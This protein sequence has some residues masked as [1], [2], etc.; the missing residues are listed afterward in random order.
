MALRPDRLQAQAMHR[1]VLGANVARNWVVERYRADQEV[2]RQAAFVLG[3]HR[4]VHGPLPAEREVYK[5]ANVAALFGWGSGRV[6]SKAEREK[7][8]GRAFAIE[9]DLLAYGE[10]ACTAAMMCSIMRIFAG[11]ARWKVK[12]GLP[13]SFEDLRWLWNR[14]KPLVLPWWSECSKEAL[15]SGIEMGALAIKNHRESLRGERLGD[16]VGMPR[17]TSIHDGRGYA[18]TTGAFGLRDARH[19]RIPKVPGLVKLAEDYEDLLGRIEAGSARL[20]RL[21]VRE[22]PDGTY[23][24]ALGLAVK[25]ESLP[26][27]SYVPRGIDLGCRTALMPSRGKPLDLARSPRRTQRA[28]MF[29]NASGV[30]K[31]LSVTP[32][33]T[34]VARLLGLCGNGE[35]LAAPALTKAR[36]WCKDFDPEHPYRALKMLL[37]NE[38]A[39][40]EIAV[41]DHQVREQ[42]TR[43][44]VASRGRRQ[45]RLSGQNIERDE[46]QRLGHS[47][48][49]KARL[50]A[51]RAKERTRR[52]KQREADK[53]RAS[54]GGRSRYARGL[55]LPRQ[56]T[57]ERLERRIRRHSQSLARKREHAKNKRALMDNNPE[58]TAVLAVLK[59]VFATLHGITLRGDTPRSRR[60]VAAKRKLASEH[61]KVVRM[62]KD[63]IHKATTR[64]ARRSTVVVVEGFNAKHLMATGGR[65]KRG[66]NRS[67]AH[68]SFGEVRRQLGYKLSRLSGA[69]L[70]APAWYPS[71]KRCSRCGQVVDAISLSERIFSCPRC[72]LV[73]DRDRNAAKNLAQAAPLLL[74]LEALEALGP[75]GPRDLHKQFSEMSGRVAPRTINGRGGN[76]SAPSTLAGVQVPAEAPTGEPRAQ[77]TEG[78]TAPAVSPLHQ[79]VA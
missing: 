44:R 60:Y 57:L 5:A 23:E 55:A 29:S 4:L 35:S 53:A 8:L 19:M 3:L 61:A 22:C 34:M 72:H 67:L 21:T 45:E 43:A 52:Q 46:T 64:E 27:P 73:I 2:R 49:R 51:K 71:T 75:I 66:L 31:A 79:E 40:D 14:E 33:T 1:D 54:S 39:L 26:T 77:R 42:Q 38:D 69:C 59:V 68:R 20:H 41:M 18:V 11:H 47:P 50:A 78:A 32:R 17:F 70:M 28:P 24:C 62:R 15:A 63:G 58:R 76:S 25:G 65:R 16:R 36:S 37:E 56:S 7:L 30:A 13:S 48:T 74:L 10:D 6:P 9:V 12:P